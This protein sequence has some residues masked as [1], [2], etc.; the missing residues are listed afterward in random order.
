MS[1]QKR[2]DDSIQ[3]DGLID[4]L[5]ILRNLKLGSFEH[6]ATQ[7]RTRCSTCGQR[8]R[9]YCFTCYEVMGDRSAVP[10][11][12]LPVHLDIL[13]YPGENEGK[14]TSL[15]ARVVCG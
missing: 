1:K 5:N 12:D 9:Y 6:M 7:E 2:I 8:R 4:G 3:S 14:A 10:Q 13:F 11:F 15:H